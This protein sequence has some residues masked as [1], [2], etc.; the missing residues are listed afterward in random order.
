MLYGAADPGAV[1][2]GRARD[3][4]CWDAA[5]CGSGKETSV[6]R[7]GGLWWMSAGLRKH[8]GG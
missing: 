4:L 3:G 7:E 1:S 8:P 2:A 5:R 6:E